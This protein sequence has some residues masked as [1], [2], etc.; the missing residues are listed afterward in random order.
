[1]SLN[2]LIMNIILNLFLKL[3]QNNLILNFIEIFNNELN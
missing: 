3:Y 1:M 2:H